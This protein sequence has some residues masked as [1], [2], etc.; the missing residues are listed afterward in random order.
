VLEKNPAQNKIQPHTLLAATIINPKKKKSD[1]TSY[2][3]EEE[4]SDEYQYY[5]I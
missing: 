1:G 2:V 5:V 3:I 4:H